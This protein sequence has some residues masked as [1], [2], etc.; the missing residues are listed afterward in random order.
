MDYTDSMRFAN[1][2]LGTFQSWDQV[3]LSE[4]NPF[5]SKMCSAYKKA[6]SC[7]EM[8]LLMQPAVL[9]HL[10][11]IPTATSTQ[12][13]TIWT[14]LQ[15]TT[16]HI[17]HLLQEGM[18][19]EAVELFQILLQKEHI[20]SIPALS[21]TEDLGIILAF[22]LAKTCL[23]CNWTHEA[24]EL[25]IFTLHGRKE[26]S[27]PSAARP[28]INEIAHSTVLRGVET[29]HKHIH[30][31][32]LRL[33]RILE[34]Y[35]TVPEA[36]A[37]RLYAGF[38]REGYID[39][40]LKLFRHPESGPATWPPP[41]AALWVLQGLH[42]RAAGSHS[43]R[44]LLR[45]L[46]KQDVLPP[47]THR[48]GIISIAAE[49]RSIEC[50]NALWLKYSDEDD[51]ELITGDPGVML[52]MVRVLRHIQTK[53]VDEPRATTDAASHG[54]LIR[55]IIEKYEDVHRPFSASQQH[56]LTA[57][58]RAYFLVGW[59]GKAVRLYREH[60]RSHS[61]SGHA[62]DEHAVTTVIKS[63]AEKDPHRAANMIDKMAERGLRPN[64]V[65]FGAV[66]HHALEAGES[67]LV[68][69]LLVRAD[70][71][72]VRV[73]D[74]TLADLIHHHA[75]R[76]KSAPQETRAEKFEDLLRIATGVH[77]EGFAKSPGL[78]KFAA[79]CALDAGQPSYAYRFWNRLVRRNEGWLSR[80]HIKLRKDISEAVV[81]LYRQGELGQDDT[82]AMLRELRCLSLLQ[83][84]TT[85]G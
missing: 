11:K 12:P 8:L 25:L 76:A 2:F 37:H 62:P 33:Y 19:S 74:K 50:A 39:L 59:S 20:E 40:A 16:S 3:D 27:V 67:E 18:D 1:E 77:T 82:E 6:D 43:A 47:L 71:L 13:T 64:G 35:Q 57:L 34:E 23:R 68:E 58:V 63:L 28:A 78:G 69:R 32:S 60:F 79:Q 17:R 9:V 29:R 65:T 51:S 81:A 45:H 49:S 66:L 22:T 21:H 75:I 54:E 53:L 30:E 72:D 80:E 42:R 73:T 83:Y 61:R 14:L 56:H 70:H 38:Q 41:T 24:L 7:K 52:R 84:G 31:A 44:R 55:D 36:A 26:S 15:Q 85:R 46:A 5:F 4:F 10:E 48:A